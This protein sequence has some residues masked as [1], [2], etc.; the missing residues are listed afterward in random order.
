MDDALRTRLVEILGVHGIDGTGM[1]LTPTEVAG[2]GG[3][4]RACADAGMSVR[5][6]S[7]PGGGGTPDGVVTV[8]LERM[9]EIDVR[10][11]S[12]TARAGAGASMAALRTAVEVAG[13]A[14]ATE[15]GSGSRGGAHVGSLI[16]RGG[17]CRRALTGIEAV[18]TTGEQIASGGRML[19]DVGPYDLAAAMLGSRGRLAIIVAATFRLVPAGADVPAH[20]PPGPLLPNQ[21]DELVRAAFDPGHVL[22]PALPS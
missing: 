21:L 4:V 17:V 16:A 9:A 20:P 2:L 5:P 12:L 8:S 7:G 10:A 14:F 19:K 1:V 3:A 13:L 15:L 22:A 11:A 6:Q 18:L